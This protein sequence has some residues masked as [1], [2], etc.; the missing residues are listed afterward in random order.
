MFRAMPR[1]ATSTGAAFMQRRI[2]MQGS[3]ASDSERS[4]SGLGRRRSRGR[5]I[6][7]GDWGSA[8]NRSNRTQ[9]PMGRTPS[10]DVGHEP[11]PIGSTPV[12]RQSTIPF[13]PLSDI[14]SSGTAGDAANVTPRPRVV[15]Y[16]N[17]SGINA[18]AT[19]VELG[20]TRGARSGSVSVTFGPN[21]L[22]AAGSPGQEDNSR[23]GVTARFKNFSTWLKKLG[24][25]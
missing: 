23:K 6:L 20:N 4:V 21:P 10:I 7:S 14:P 25:H 16:Q 8:F 9:S 1:R 2:Q 12:S 3:E 22:L 19:D 17:H 15:S 5:R 18:T 13:P 11:A 24:A